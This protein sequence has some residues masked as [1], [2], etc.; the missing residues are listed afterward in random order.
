[1]RTSL[2]GHTT[3]LLTSSS[4][5]EVMR[6]ASGVDQIAHVRIERCRFEAFLAPG[7]ASGS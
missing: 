6:T 5:D 3:L 4:E 7:A 2:Y 1:M